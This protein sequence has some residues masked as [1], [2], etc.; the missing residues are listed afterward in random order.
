M[1]SEYLLGNSSAASAIELY[2]PSSITVTF[3]GDDKLLRADGTKYVDLSGVNLAPESTLVI[4]N[5]VSTLPDLVAESVDVLVSPKLQVK[6]N[7]SWSLQVDGTVV[8]VVGRY[9][10]E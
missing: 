10:A 1:I 6:K 3:D 2:N 5:G 9:N 4:V 7:E 8:D